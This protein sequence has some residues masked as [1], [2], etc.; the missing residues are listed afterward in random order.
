[1]A[2]R[3]STISIG[4]QYPQRPPF[5]FHA[6]TRLL[7]KHAVANVVTA[8]GCWFLVQIAVLEDSK[9]YC[10]AVAWTDQ[11][12]CPFLGVSPSKLVRIRRKCVEAGWLH[13]EPGHRGTPSR[14][15]VTVPA[16]V[17]S[18]P[19]ANSIQDEL[20]SVLSANPECKRSTNEAQTE[21]KRSASGALLPYTQSNNPS[22]TPNGGGGEIETDQRATPTLSGSADQRPSDTLPADSDRESVVRLLRDAGVSRA[23]D[24]ADRALSI[25]HTP[26]SVQ[27]VCEHFR[28]RPGF[29]GAGALRYRLT[30]EDL[31]GSAPDDDQSWPTP[32]ATAAARFHSRTR[33][34]LAAAA[35]ANVAT[36]APDPEREQR[37]EQLRQL[38]LQFSGALDHASDDEVIDV[39]I[40]VDHQK[41]LT[42]FRRR[43]R[44]RLIRPALLR[45]FA[46]AAATN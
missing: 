23:G 28:A 31:V 15:W 14:Y 26:Q 42:E 30:D 43:G 39:L 32:D 46:A 38:E 3:Q 34:D 18:G 5:F 8:E 16:W 7:L 10:Q 12:L 33:R 11:Q 20:T 25:G 13:F 2:A 29:W 40:R 35:L 36:P 1:M 4:E 6:F 41:T 24:T 27:A 44:T 19:H 45:A 21:C 9:R 37:V 22:P 17:P